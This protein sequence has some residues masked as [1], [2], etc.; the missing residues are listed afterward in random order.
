MGANTNGRAHPM[1]TIKTS[2]MACGDVELLI[3]DLLLELL[4]GSQTGTYTFDCPFCVTAQRR[5]ANQRVV[6]ILLATG[7]SYVVAS[8]PKLTLSEEQEVETFAAILESD[9]WFQ[10]LTTD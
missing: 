10:N 4:P 5:P 8:E 9:D 6:S 2:C 7:V 1:T 3:E